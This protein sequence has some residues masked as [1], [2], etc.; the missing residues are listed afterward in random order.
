ME[1]KYIFAIAVLG[2]FFLLIFISFAFLEYGRIKEEKLQAW[3]V[4][5]YSIKKVKNY[6]YAEDNGEEISTQSPEA[7]AVNEDV[8]EESIPEVHLDDPYG[9]IDI[10]GIEEI[11]GNYNGDK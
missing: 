2:V 7:A 11:T 1:F 5:Q 9:K 3:I 10:E 8:E 6:E 4:E